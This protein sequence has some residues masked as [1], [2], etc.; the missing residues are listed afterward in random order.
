MQISIK[1]MDYYLLISEPNP[2]L[3]YPNYNQF[4]KGLESVIPT[5]QVK[6]NL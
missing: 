3:V 5:F 6:H 4:N 2:V 1:S